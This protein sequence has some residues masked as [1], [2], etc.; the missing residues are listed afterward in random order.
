MSRLDVQTLQLIHNAQW[1]DHN[2]M[3][4][5]LIGQ[6]ILTKVFQLDYIVVINKLHPFSLLIYLH[7]FLT[8]GQQGTLVTLLWATSLHFIILD[9][10]NNFVPPAL[11]C[12]DSHPPSTYPF[13]GA[14]DLKLTTEFRLRGVVVLKQSRRKHF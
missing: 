12:L 9:L 5:P 2:V 7:S 13:D 3:S 4:R 8:S 6:W 1:M 11:S 14:V 10:L